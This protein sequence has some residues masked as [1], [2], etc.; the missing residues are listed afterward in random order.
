MV[1]ITRS[2]C[3]RLVRT[4]ARY[5]IGGAAKPAPLLSN[6]HDE[7]GVEL[8]PLHPVVAARITHNPGPPE[9]FVDAVV[10]VPVDPERRL[11]AHN[12]R[13]EVRRKTGVQPTLLE[14]WPD[15]LRAGR[16]VSDDD[17]R[18][19]GLFRLLQFFFDERPL[20]GV[21]SC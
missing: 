16:V 9:L 1:L 11:V 10:L 4:C 20:R 14:P 12:H 18:E 2:G 15:G 21:A 5:V 7:P 6:L 8:M 17:G 3:F 19:P 13:I